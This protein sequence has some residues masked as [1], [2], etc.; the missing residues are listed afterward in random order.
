MTDKEFLRKLL[1]TFRTEAEEHLRDIVSNI[2]HLEQAGE[3]G[4]KDIV[5]R[6][7]R[8][9]HTLKGAARSVNLTDLEM[10]CHAMESV[11]SAV[12][13]TGGTF[14]SEQFD[15]VHQ[16]STLAGQLCREESTGRLRNQA[17]D[18]AQWLERLGEETAVAGQ[19]RA[20]APP[21][22]AATPQAEVAVDASAHADSDMPAKADVI[23]VQGKNLDAIRY[24]VEALLS[25]E[26]GLHHHVVELLALAD[27]M[28]R[29]RNVERLSSH[30][31]TGTHASQ[32]AVR[33]VQETAIGEGFEQRCRRAAAALGRTRQ[34]FA[35]IRSRLMDATLDTALVPLSTALEHLPGLVRNLARSSGKEVALKIQGEGIL[36]DR[37]ILDVVREAVIHLA[38]N[39]VDHGI[40]PVDTRRAE[41]KPA[42]G[43]ITVN[44]AQS[45]SSRIAL[46][47]VD[48]GAGIDVEGVV[49]AAV[50]GGHLS[51]DQ[52]EGFSENQRLQLALRAGV[53]TSRELTQVSGR[54][55]GL[56]V[57]ADKV[58][59]VGGA[60]SIESRRGAGC[61]FEL[62]LPVRLST[63]RGLVLRAG[64]TSWVLPLSGVEA[65]R[66]LRKGDIQ[67]VESRETLL[68]RGNVVP[69]VR[70][71]KAL[72][73]QRAGAA[74]PDAGSAVIVRTGGGT[75]ALLVD[76]VL[77][78]QEVLPKSLGGPLRRVRFISGAT[79][80]G[81]GSLVPILG[82]EDLAKLGLAAGSL[83]PAMREES[84]VSSA[85]RVLIVEDSIT[86]RLLLKHIL[87]GAGYQVVTAVDGL[88]ALSRLRQ[89]Q[90]DAVVSDVE[91]PRMDGLTLTERIRGNPK[92]EEMPVVLVTSLQSPEEKERGLRA[93]ADAYVVK[94]AF[95]QDNLLKTI[96]RLI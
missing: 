61:T 84:A 50:K 83:G 27:D 35:Q 80:L 4:R 74:D 81:D 1:I 11:F 44:I 86:S 62:Q 37:R 71:D 45:G 65:V 46:T 33:E 51:A 13:K 89:E 21:E 92:T 38:T 96:R 93:G 43:E 91:M 82:L 66:A 17:A 25:V 14:A 76:E 9:L 18:L 58:A 53:S 42:A 56:A 23:R 41:G 34:N 29:Q 78:E 8:T 90:F 30:A 67:T 87:E 79:Q 75:F 16:A 77:S 48:D 73:L 64:D 5:E 63:L 6:L 19:A 32:R 15:L 85:R 26:L 49:D 39:A 54:G 10:L 72:G 20:A 94:G 88:D 40:E 69:A 68:V 7:L 57:V 55:V 95:D 60:L 24:Q 3:G 59:S 52:L 22:S 12:R 70:L 31:K 36:I 47:V 2:V 28:A